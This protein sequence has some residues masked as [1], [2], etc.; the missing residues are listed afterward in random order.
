MNRILLF[1]LWLSCCCAT[2]L[3]Y[4][5]DKQ[6]I[7]IWKDAKGKLNIKAQM[8]RVIGDDVV[9]RRVN[10]KTFVVPLAQLSRADQAF[11]KRQLT[12]QPHLGRL[13][14]N[15][16]C[17]DLSDL[18]GQM[19]L[20]VIRSKQIL[21]RTEDWEHSTWKADD[22]D[23]DSVG[24]PCVVHNNRG[25]NPDGKYYLYYAHH[26]PTSGIGCAVAEHI[27]GPY[28]KLKVLDPK[29]KHSMVLVNPHSPGKV[30]D[31]SHYSTPSLV[32]N[33]DEQLWFMYFHYYNHFH[34]LWE[35]DPNYP[36]GGNQMTALATSPDLASHQW[37]IVKDKSLAKV[38]VHDI[39][40][41]LTT[42][43][44]PW[45]YGTSSYNV[46]Q[47]LPT[48][49]WIAF[50]RGT[51][52]KGIPTVGFARSDDGRAWNY[53]AENP[54]LKSPSSTAKTIHRSGFI[55][56]LGKD[57]DGKRQ[58]LVVW[59]ESKLGADVPKVRYGSTTD[60]K[61]IH[62]DPRGFAK[63]PAGDGFISPWREGNLLYLFA[64]QHMH[65]MR[66]P[67]AR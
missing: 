26:D 6:P 9:L 56:Y 52:K 8:V 18:N 31:P 48:G 1:V 24:Y 54:I 21:R 39:L 66:L 3:V 53:F 60:F 5:Q 62:P 19:P 15:L 10:K 28:R 59:T 57:D 43:K 34:R 11:V 41:V 12:N 2:S 51:S 20:T 30:G 37:T 64:G 32:W 23:R 35:E 38:S 58:Y 46:I 50:L 42:S 40:P 13:D 7:R 27:G 17:V 63:W 29:R 55:G 25:K 47:R 65:V 67:V 45:M 4:S 22:P 33:D 49:E 14:N 36:G 61:T 44:E 16:K